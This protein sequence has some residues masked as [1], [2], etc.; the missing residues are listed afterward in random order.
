MR[1][2][3]KQESR[4]DKIIRCKDESHNRNDPREKIR[5]VGKNL[6]EDHIIRKIP[7]KK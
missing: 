5:I 6:Y 1:D 2:D 7:L 4:D 3:A